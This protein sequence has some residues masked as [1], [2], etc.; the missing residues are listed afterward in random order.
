MGDLVDMEMILVRRLARQ[1]KDLQ[2][3]NEVLA[4]VDPLLREPVRQLIL[5]LLSF[6]VEDAIHDP[7]HGA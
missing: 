6:K 7:E 1:I 2:H 5:P 3:L 4:A